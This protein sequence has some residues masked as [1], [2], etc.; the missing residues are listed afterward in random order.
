[1]DL[2]TVEKLQA[3]FPDVYQAVLKT[4]FDTGHA[5]GLAKG[6]EAG[7]AAG[8]EKERAR[9][10]GIEEGALPGHEALIAQMKFDGKTTPEQAAVRILQA[11]KTLRETKLADLK[12]DAPPVVNTV[13]P[14]K[15]KPKQAVATDG[16]MTDEQMQAAWDSDGGLKVEFGTFDAY[17]AYM[18]AEQRGLVKIYGKKGGK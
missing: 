11:E 15:D 16:T 8:S 13:D 17:K 14:E 9:I 6:T 1:M 2:L 5:E 7:F 12:T 10:K 4:G 18:D 3:A